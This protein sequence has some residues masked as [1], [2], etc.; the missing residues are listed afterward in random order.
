MNTFMIVT[1][2]FMIVIFG[3][4]LIMSHEIEGLKK[5]LDKLKKEN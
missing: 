4:C 3:L 5:E 2:I 1:I